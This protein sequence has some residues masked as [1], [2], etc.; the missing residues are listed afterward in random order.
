MEKIMVK[1]YNSN[2]DK[3]QEV[4]EMF[5]KIAYK[6][7][8]LNRLLSLGVDQSWRKAAVNYL[9][10]DAPKLILD[11]ATGTG[12][13]AIQLAQTLKPQK[14]YGVDIAVDM[15]KIGEEKIKD[16]HLEQIIELREGDSED[17]K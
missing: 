17:L 1:P 2:A 16:K 5:N 10:E 3:K 12:D 6:Y 14:I 7:D 15:L 13:L 9:K 8:F 4:S 11:V